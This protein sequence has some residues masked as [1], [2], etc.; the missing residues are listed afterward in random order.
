MEHFPNLEAKSIRDAPYGACIAFA[1]GGATC[2]GI[3]LQPNHPGDDETIAVLWTTG[4][5]ELA[6]RIIALESISG[7]EIVIF[8]TAKAVL[9]LDPEHI[10]FRYREHAE[11][12]GALFLTNGEPHVMVRGQNNGSIAVRLRD[13]VR[14]N[15]GISNLPWFSSWTIA[16]PSL[17]G[18]STICRIEW[19]KE[20]EG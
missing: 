1:M 20:A 15:V 19:K 6:P 10:R 3:T 7:D 8:L 12:Y 18:W 11:L 13:G 14:A 2:V 9:P 17:S 4:R 5:D 16:S